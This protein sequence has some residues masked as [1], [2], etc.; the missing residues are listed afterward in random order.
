MTPSSLLIFTYGSNLCLHRLR[1]RTPSAS[2]IGIARLPGHDLR[3]HKVGKDG[4]GKC[5][6]FATGNPGDEVWGGVM[7]IDAGE[8]ARLDRAEHL[9]IGYRARSVSLA[10][11]PIPIGTNPPCRGSLSPPLEMRIYT[12]LQIDP[13]LRPF[14]WYRGYVLTGARAV[15]LPRD[16]IGRISGVKAC[17]DPDEERARRHWRALARQAGPPG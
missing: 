5:D 16:Y 4:S 6:A 3:W 2:L 10:L 1:R 8:R 9:G 17:R 15:G 11:E 13:H 7:R 14:D 12:A